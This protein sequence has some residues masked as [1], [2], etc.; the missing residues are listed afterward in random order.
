[1]IGSA[2]AAITEIVLEAAGRR[3][4]PLEL[5]RNDKLTHS[6]IVG[7]VPPADPAARWSAWTAAVE[8]SP[9]DLPPRP[10]LHRRITAAP[11]NR[12]LRWPV[13]SRRHRD[14]GRQRRW[15]PLV[16]RDLHY[17]GG[18]PA[19]PGELDRIDMFFDNHGIR[20][21]RAGER[22]GS[23]PGTTSS[24]C[25]STPR[26]PPPTCRFPWSGCSA[27]SPPYSRDASGVSCCGL[28]IPAVPGCSPLKESV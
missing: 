16:L 25:P 5:Y 17:L 6:V 20:F 14:R 10:H 7:W 15:R 2:D 4:V 22:L 19:A 13:R 28:L 11:P 23:T 21:E 27:S 26:T 9:A 24:T 1:M 3:A 12:C 18:H 8:R